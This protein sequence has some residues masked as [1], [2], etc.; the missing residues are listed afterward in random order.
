[1]AAPV[2][3]LS[4]YLF[5]LIIFTDNPQRGEYFHEIINVLITKFPCRVI[6]IESDES[7]KQESPEVSK[8]DVSRKCDQIHIRVSDPNINQLPYLL[9]PIL[10]PD[11]PVYLIWG[12]NPTAQS[13][14]LPDLLKLT[15]R[16]I[17][18]SESCDNLKHFSEQ[19]LANLNIDNIEFMDI[20]WA[21]IRGWR[22]V[23]GKIFDSPEKLE[24]LQ[25]CQSIK[26]HYNDIESVF[27]KH[28]STRA[29]Y[30]QGWLAGQME[31]KYVSQDESNVL[32]YQNGDIQ[33]RVELIKEQ[34]HEM[35]PGTILKVVIHTNKNEDVVVSKISDQSMVHVHITRGDQCE[36]P[37]S[38]RLPNFQRGLSFI[39]EIFYYRTTEHYKHMLQ[40]IKNIDWKP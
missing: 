10:V 16:I 40:T 28:L 30:L 23:L 5:N 21:L 37:F 4:G 8:L 32:Y 15:T 3:E 1:M 11:L 22:E 19:I 24:M 9:L 20:D 26:I 6:F 13:R 14:I 18:D 27:F 38:Y 12:Q 17:Y 2:K 39:K 34:K 25:R 33:L 29:F 31:W 36:L 7:L 35:P